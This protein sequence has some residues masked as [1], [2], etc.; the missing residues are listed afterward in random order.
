MIKVS[1]MFSDHMVLQRR[2]NISVFGTGSDGAIVKV[3]LGGDTAHARV[4]DGKWNAILPAREAAEGL[5][6]TVTSDSFERT[7]TDVAVG[8]VWLAGGQSNME[9][10]LQN[11]TTGQ[12]HLAEDAGVNV[13][14][15]YVQKI[16]NKE[17]NYEEVITNNCWK[18][19]DSESAK[20]WSA[21]GYLF[22]KRLSEKLGC[23]VGVI[24]CNWGGTKACQWM[25]RESLETDT[26]L[27]F[28]YDK[29]LAAMKGK[30]EE[31]MTQ[32]YREYENY[33][34]EWNKRSAEY[35]S[36]ASD[37]TWDE[38]QK[39][40]GVCRYPGPPLPLNPFSPT[41]LYNSMIKVVCP[42][43]LAGFLYYQG[44]SD[45]DNPQNYYKLLR[46][47]IDVWR[48][49]WGDNDLPFLIV[50][51]PMH[52]Y[53][54]D[55]DRK[56]WCVIREAQEKV[57]R[58]VRNT[59]LAVAI[60]CGE[61]NEIHPHDKEAVA[62][63]LYQRALAF[64]G[65]DG[66]PPLL[67]KSVLPQDGSV[68]VETDSVSE[69]EIRGSKTGFELAGADGEYRPADFSVSGT[70]ITVSSPEVPE[71]LHVRYLW[72]NY[73]ADIPVYNKDG[74]PLAPFRR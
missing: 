40:C 73:S 43:T 1:P 61:F 70:K 63:R 74:E 44:E 32:E 46:G 25:S 62:E 7:F 13:R 66:R 14:F 16:V 38:C 27:R 68:V 67:V 31:Q 41:T 71:P 2:K 24:G 58:T 56:N 51:L 34:I 9:Y 5:T 60:D 53:K 54:G 22:A 12:A 42:Y 17:P 30:T 6:L 8:E 26:D 18:T 69:L 19:F 47:L 20:N 15:Y 33:S 45:D 57:Y 23:I 29:A 39:V 4:I 59:G 72:T 65:I 28:D 49:D 64:F 52:L 10:E 50:Q 11:C 48:T 55:L 37:P 36:T 3:A 35:Y 21:V